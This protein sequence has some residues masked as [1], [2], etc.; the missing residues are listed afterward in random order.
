[1]IKVKILNTN[2]NNTQLAQNELNKELEDLQKNVSIRQ[3]SMNLINNQ[4]VFLIQYE[5][6]CNS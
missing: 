1:M 5:N 2:T 3:I 6:N 4:I